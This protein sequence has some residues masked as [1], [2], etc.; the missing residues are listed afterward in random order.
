MRRFA[1][2]VLI[3][4]AMAV[5][6]GCLIGGPGDP[7]FYSAS[8]CDGCWRGTWGGREGW[9]RGGGRPWEQPHHEGDHLGEGHVGEGP[10]H[11]GHH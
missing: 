8:P 7:Y 6:T 2:G 3:L 11:E 10:M 1:T 5:L 9:H 4:M